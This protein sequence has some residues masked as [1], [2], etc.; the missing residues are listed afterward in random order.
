M[1]QCHTLKKNP[2][3]F[4][5][6]NE[7]NDRKNPIRSDLTSF[8]FGRQDEYER[9]Q[10]SVARLHAE[11]E[12]AVT[13]VEKVREELERCQSTLGKLQLQ[14]DK[15]QQAHD[16]TQNEVD[17]LQERLEKAQLEI[18]KVRT[19]A[20][21]M[22]WMASTVANKK[23]GAFCLLRSC[24]ARRRSWRSST[25]TSRLSWTRRR[26]SARASKKRKRTTSW[27]SNASV[28]SKR[29]TR[30]SFCFP[31][32]TTIDLDSVFFHKY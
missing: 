21:T 11:R 22:C 24:K 29:N 1:P 31:T 3:S 10:G 26:A 16:K 30:C 15:T 27:K 20:S 2:I 19:L 25:T 18:R 7:R 6:H 14:Q 12:K 9:C 17:R 5:F 4:L 23:N 32:T 8:F 13:D 28:R